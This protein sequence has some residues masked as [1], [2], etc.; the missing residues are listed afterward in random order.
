MTIKVFFIAYQGAGSILAV[1]ASVKDSS[2]AWTGYYQ[3]TFTPAVTDTAATIQAAAQSDMLAYLA[4]LGM[5][6]PDSLEWIISTVS[7]VSPV[8]ANP[9]RSLNSAFQI[10]A[11]RVAQVSY[12]VSISCAISLTTGQQGTVYLEYADDSG[13]TTNVVTV[14]SF[15]NGNTGSL[16]LGLALTQVN[17]AALA[18]MIP[19]GKY[20][21][22]RT[23]NNT[24]SPTFAFVGAQEVLV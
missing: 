21:R 11:S 5:P 20:V 22:L 7:P 18:G 6:T 12:A 16:T 23:Q 17:T 9:T 3:A 13:F 8:F 1:D 2:G 15:T 19:V 10:S 14:N 24:G 4:G